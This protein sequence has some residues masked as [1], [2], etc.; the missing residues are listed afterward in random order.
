[1]RG[2]FACFKLTQ[3]KSTSYHLNRLLTSNYEHDWALQK[4]N[5]AFWRLKKLNFY[6]DKSMPMKSYFV[7]CRLKHLSMGKWD[8][9]KT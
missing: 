6:L 7:L 9:V 2:F 1:M 3:K 8:P 5:N 4:C